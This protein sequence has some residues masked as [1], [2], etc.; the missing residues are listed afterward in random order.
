MVVNLILGW[1]GI[2]GKNRS[3][4]D[5][6]AERQKMLRVAEQM[7]ASEGL[8]LEIPESQEE[9][10]RSL[11]KM[12]ESFEAVKQAVGLSPEDFAILVSSPEYKEQKANEREYWEYQATAQLRIPLRYLEKNGEKLWQEEEPPLEGPANGVSEWEDGTTHPFNHFG[13]WVQHSTFRDWMFP[14]TPEH[15]KNHQNHIEFLIEFRKIIEDT[16]RDI[17]QRIGDAYALADADIYKDSVAI[18]CQGDWLED[19]LCHELSQLNGVG[20]KKARMFYDYGY[21]TPEL[22]LT[23]SDEE[24]L[25]FKGIGK[26]FIEKLRN[27][28]PL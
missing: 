9:L 19:F 25:R 26:K 18:F 6:D 4:K 22:L 28:N 10:N 12:S 13:R 27:E 3:S 5:R 11:G 17:E 16:T 1:L 8:E 24:L 23:A 2:K 20:P 21:K 14:S 7:A 15:K